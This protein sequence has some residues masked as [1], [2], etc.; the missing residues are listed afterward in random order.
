MKKN[1]VITVSVFAVLIITGL[2]LVLSFTGNDAKEAVNPADEFLSSSDAVAGENNSEIN[3]DLTPAEVAGYYIDNSDGWYYSFT[4]AP[5]GEYDGSFSA[6]FDASHALTDQNPQ[7]A[8][9]A[10]GN[11]KLEKGE[12]ELYSEGVY[13]SSMWVCGDYIVDSLNY[14]VGHIDP[15]DGKIQSVFVSKAGESGDTQVFNLYSDGKLIMEIIR[16]DGTAD[17]AAQSSELP[18]YQMLAG[19][20]AING[21]KIAITIG[22]AVQEYYVV[23]D[24]FA[25]WKYVKK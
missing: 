10:G 2:I 7:S 4:H 1:S 14:F 16:N 17:S 11:W 8:F 25:K 5:S 15:D 6:G 23:N 12:I 24:G 3:T 9:T 18:P 22:T 19:T 21:D 20:Y 13:R